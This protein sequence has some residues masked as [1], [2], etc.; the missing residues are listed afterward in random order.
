MWSTGQA[1][2]RKTKRSG[3]GGGRFGVETNKQTLNVRGS[4]KDEKYIYSLKTKF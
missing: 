2:T 3:A 1:H 4:M